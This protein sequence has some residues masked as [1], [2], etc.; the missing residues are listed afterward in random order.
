[1]AS[2]FQAL[3][4]DVQQRVLLGLPLDDLSA[5]AA[6]CKA[7]RAVIRGPK[8]LALR[9][10][11][12]F[13]E[14]GVVVLG[15]QRPTAQGAQASRLAVVGRRHMTGIF[16]GVPISSRGATTDGARLFVST[17]EFPEEKM[18]AVNVSSRRWKRLTTLPR[19]QR[20]HCSEWHRGILYVAGG[21]GTSSENGSDFHFL[22]SVFAFSEATGL[23]EELPPMPHDCILAASGVIGNQL[24]IAGGQSEQGGFGGTELSTLQ[25]Y[26]IATGTWRLGPP[27]P[28]PRTDGIG[29]VAGGKLFLVSQRDLLNYDPNSETWTESETCYDS[30]QMH[31]ACVHNDRIIVFLDTGT[32]WARAADGSWAYYEDAAAL[33]PPARR[34]SH[35]GAAEH[36]VS[37]S[38]LLG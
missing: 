23:W 20:W 6:A 7:F 22:N 4:D 33:G 2:P 3:P 12:G 25:I 16:E 9:Q 31:H 13:A 8:F 11:Y 5:A 35:H 21:C 1:M 18:L 36:Y 37:E 17:L 30:S 26:D 14:R 38:V 10:R 28:G 32:A 19:K 27:L 34:G 24:F 29:L 15:R